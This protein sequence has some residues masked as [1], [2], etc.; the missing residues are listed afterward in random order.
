M[1]PLTV[2]ITTND[3]W[4]TTASVAPELEAPLPAPEVVA[5]EGGMTRLDRLTNAVRLT[6]SAVEAWASL[7]DPAGSIRAGEQVVLSR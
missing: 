2:R 1:I 5:V 7:M 3:Y 4:L 6:R